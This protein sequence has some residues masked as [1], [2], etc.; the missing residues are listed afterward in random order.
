MENLDN[1]NLDINNEKNKNNEYFES[2][3]NEFIFSEND[4]YII[5]SIGINENNK[6]LKFNQLKINIDN[7]NKFE[8]IEFD[9]IVDNE[10]EINIK[11][12]TPGF[13]LNYCLFKNNKEYENFP[14]KNVME[15]EKGKLNTLIEIK[16]KYK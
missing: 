13:V 9:N 15:K 10:S 12:L 14:L 1:I 3:T 8:S 2:L 6:T 11:G 4:S 5:K 16:K 7:N